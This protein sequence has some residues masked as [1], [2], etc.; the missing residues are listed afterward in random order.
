[1][2]KLEFVK[3][4]C[5]KNKYTQKTAIKVITEVLDTICET[6]AKNERIDLRNFGTFKVKTYPS[7]IGCDPRNREVI[8]IPTS[9]R[10]Y[11]KPSKKWIKTSSGQ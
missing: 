11:F 9:K 1:M 10:V 4:F 3:T 7:R 2:N 8:E 5:E 6:F